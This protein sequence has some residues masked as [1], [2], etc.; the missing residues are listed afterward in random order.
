MSLAAKT[1]IV[2]LGSAHGDDQAGWLVAEMLQR[3]ASECHD[4]S[5]RKALVPLDVLD[6]LEDI[7]VLHLC[8]ACESTSSDRSLLKFRWEA[9]RLVSE[10]SSGGHPIHISNAPFR[11]RGSHDF[12]VPE[13]LRL[14][15]QIGA[16]PKH[17]FLWAVAGFQF[18]PGDVLCEQTRRSAVQATE[19]ILK[20]VAVRAR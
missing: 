6:W 1:L 13:M 2:G 10:L 16:L 7:N 4:V 11:S 20:A 18:Q 3:S 15:E 8:D 9:G 12:G 19:E 5:V 17:V 14:A